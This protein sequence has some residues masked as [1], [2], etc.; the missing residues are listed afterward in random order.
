MLLIALPAAVAAGSSSNDVKLGQFIP[1]S[2]AQPE[3]QVSLTTLAGKPVSLSDFKGEPLVVN[4]WATWCQPCLAEM[5]SLD[6]FQQRNGGRIQVLAVSE[7][8]T[9]ASK[10]QPFIARMN[11]KALAIYLD[12]DG[13]LLQA[14]GARGLPTTIVIDAQGR[15]VGKIEGASDWNSPQ[16]AQMLQPYLLRGNPGITTPASR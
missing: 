1:V 2:P 4:L 13:A 12:P 10:V 3:P 8:Q 6:Q 11:L 15:M 7:D 9:G 5:P 16:I 14:V